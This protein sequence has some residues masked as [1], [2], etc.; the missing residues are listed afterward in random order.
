MLFFGWNI[1][2][3]WMFVT[4]FPGLQVMGSKCQHPQEAH[5]SIAGKHH[6]AGDFLSKDTACYPESLAATF[7]TI[8]DPLLS[9]HHQDL[10]WPFPNFI[11]PSKGHDDFP[12]SSEDGGGL[13]SLP[14][15]SQANRQAVDSL[16]HLRTTWRQ[17]ILDQ[18]LDR[19]LLAYVAQ[20]PCPEP[21]FSDE[22]LQPFMQVLHEFILSHGI[23]PDWSA[24]EHQPMQLGILSALSTIMSDKDITLFEAL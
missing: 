20:G 12:K 5:E 4:S 16:K 1:H 18:R 3:A 7:A 11:L 9:D 22:T 15:W 23:S 13:F 6:L 10:S 8:I 24:R 17:M 21:P 19:K 2:K 14:D